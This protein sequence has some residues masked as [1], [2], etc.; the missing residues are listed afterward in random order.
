MNSPNLISGAKAFDQLGNTCVQEMLSELIHDVV[1]LVV[2][3]KYQIHIP[4]L[5]KQ[6][7]WLEIWRCLVD[8]I[9]LGHGTL[10]PKQKTQDLNAKSLTSPIDTA[11]D[12]SSHPRDLSNKQ[13]FL[14]LPMVGNGAVTPFPLSNSWPVAK[15]SCSCSFKPKTPQLWPKM[16]VF[17]CF[18]KRCRYQEPNGIINSPT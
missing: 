15:A 9:F 3:S 4:K 18:Q 14:R 7:N 2:F 13:S 1:F 8:M 12:T 16:E 17:H 11:G 5:P 10:L 6:T